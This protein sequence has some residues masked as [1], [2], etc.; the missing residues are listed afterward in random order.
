[1]ASIILAPTTLA[2]TILASIILVST[3]LVSTGV[4]RLRT[5]WL[6]GI[7]LVHGL[8]THLL[9]FAVLILALVY[10]SPGTIHRGTAEASANTTTLELHHDE[11]R[12]LRVDELDGAAGVQ[13]RRTATRT[14]RLASDDTSRALASSRPEAMAC[15]GR[16]AA[17]VCVESAPHPLTRTRSHN[18][19]A[20]PL[21]QP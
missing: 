16:Y 17:Q 21:P 13:R 19:R 18:P 3:I 8:R 4:D 15:S 20:P 6:T 2:S 10:P 5:D 7:A 1:M 12:A 11:P 9:A 14:L